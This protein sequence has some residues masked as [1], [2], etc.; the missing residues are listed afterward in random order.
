MFA[1]AKIFGVMIAC[2]SVVGFLLWFR[3]TPPYRL[4]NHTTPE[5]TQLLEKIPTEYSATTTVQRII[6]PAVSTSRA[7]PPRVIQSNI[8]SPIIHQPVS[9]SIPVPFQA[10]PVVSSTPQGMPVGA[11]S[12]SQSPMLPPPLV[13]TRDLQLDEAALLRAVVKIE[14]PTTD[15]LGKYVGSGFVMPGNVVV[16]A[17]HVI[18]DSGSATCSVIFSHDRVPVHYLK[19]TIDDLKEVQRRH[20]EQGI[21]LAVIHLPALESYPEAQAIFTEYPAI[22]YPVCTD[23]N[24]LGDTLLHFGYPANFKDQSYLSELQGEAVLFA[25][26]KGIKNQLSADQT[27]TFKSPIFS[28][29]GDETALHPYMVSRVG[30]YYGD[31]G[32]LAF[33]ATKQCILGPHR[34]ASIGSSSGENY[35]VFMVLGWGNLRDL[36]K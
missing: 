20:D 5:I 31:S 19:G 36:I 1:T 16:T 10:A 9:P 12:T 27:Y 13:S 26:I 11:S 33:D 21:D 6:A 24:L 7:E 8:T 30:T 23:A 35:S 3:Q 28:F 2:I 34:G 25:D 32:G 22:P 4:E 17:A 18:K 15:G 29:T 14:C